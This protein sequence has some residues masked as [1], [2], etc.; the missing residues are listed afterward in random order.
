KMAVRRRKPL[1]R[2]RFPH[3][4][5]TLRYGKIFIRMGAPV[6]AEHRGAFMSKFA[7]L[8]LDGKTLELP[9]LEGSEGEKAVD[10]RKLRDQ[11]GYITL[12]SG[13]GNTGACQS[14][15]TFIDGE[16]GIL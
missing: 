15:I 2:N 14:A 4:L 8:K 7:E 1:C 10:I 16:A 6:V 12:D 3:F 5:E 13:Y 11:S 9:I